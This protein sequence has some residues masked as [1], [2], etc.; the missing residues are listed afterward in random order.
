V[1][2]LAHTL[3]GA[4]LG[5]ALRESGAGADRRAVP[6]AAAVLAANIPDVDALAYLVSSA[7][8]F[9]NAARFVAMTTFKDACETISKSGILR[10][11]D[12]TTLTAE[13]VWNYSPTG[14]LFMIPEWYDEAKIVLRLL[15]AKKAGWTNLGAD[16]TGKPVGLP[17]HAQSPC[18]L[19][20]VPA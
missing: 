1:E 6:I 8:S 4:A 9:A 18:D 14:E 15:N 7:G 11:P 17:P 10:R 12:G 13:E 3:F 2:P 19:E 5:H 20:E 16:P